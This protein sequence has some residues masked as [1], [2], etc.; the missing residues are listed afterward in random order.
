[1]RR[2]EARAIAERIRTMLDDGEQLVVDRDRDA[3]TETLRA[4]QPRDVVLLFRALSDVRYYEEALREQAIRYYLVGGHAFYAQ[5]EIFDLANLLGAVEDPNDSLRL[6]GALR[7]PF[8]S[9]Q[10][11]TLYWLAGEEQDLAQGLSDPARRKHLSSDQ[12]RRVE[13]AD[14]VLTRLRARKDRVPIAEL[15]NDALDSTGYDAALLAEFLGRRQ[16][17][18]LHKLIDTARRFDGA[19]LFTLADLSRS[20]SSSSASTRWCPSTRTSTSSPRDCRN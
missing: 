16:L 8:F 7:S 18:N 10:D 5:Q 13:F 12:R 4:A 15:I 2:R 19:G 14:E 3:G 11:E 9:L 17:A 20:W 1:M 6:A